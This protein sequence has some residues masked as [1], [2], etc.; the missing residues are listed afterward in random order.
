MQTSLDSIGFYTLSEQRAATASATTPLSRCELILTGR[1]NFKC[2]YCRHVGGKDADYLEAEYTVLRWGAEGLKA[3]RFSGGEP[4][5][6]PRLIDL[7]QLSKKLGV[8]RIAVSTN[9]SA[10]MEFY[11]R[12]MQAGVNDF[13]VSLDACCA[14]DGDKMAGGVK[15][16]WKTVISN[17]AFLSQFTYV[18]VGVVLTA[19]NVSRV[20]DTIRLADSLGVADIRVIPAAQVGQRLDEIDVDEVVLARHPILRYRLTNLLNGQAVRGLSGADSNRC[21]LVV[22]DM[23]V[24]N[25]HHYPC[26]IYMREGGAPI[27]KIDS[28]MRG[29]RNVWARLHDT[30]LDPIC[31]Q[32]CLDVCVEYNN[33]FAA[34]R[35][36][37][38]VAA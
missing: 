2:P 22:D 9:G 11:A 29:T 17:I 34:V 21:G 36:I 14:E 4:T 25:G 6:Y 38:D 35:S 10:S 5:L 32:N 20:G 15:G 19:E 33:R 13:S 12:L 27:G 7:V 31:Q 8:Q 1:C 30:H 26:I 37:C 18:T 16:A 23:A 3:I 28:D 24:M